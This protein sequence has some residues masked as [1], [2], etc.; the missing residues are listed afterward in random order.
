MAVGVFIV[1][2]GAVAVRTMDS[3]ESTPARIPEVGARFQY[4]LGDLPVDLSAEADVFDID[5]FDIDLFDVPSSTV[6]ELH[7]RG[8]T[9]VCYLSDGSFEGVRPDA[10]RFPDEVVGAP[11]QGFPDERWLDLRATD[12]LLPIMEDRLDQ[13]AAKG[14]DGVEFDNV[15]A[16]ANDSGFELTTDDQLAYLMA[17]SAAARDRDLSP[18]SEI[19]L[20]LGPEVVDD[21]DRAL[22][23][24]CFQ[25]DECDQAAPFVDRD[26]AVFV[27][28]YEVD[29]ADVCDR[30]TDGLSVVFKDLDL[31][32]ELMMCP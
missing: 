26:K 28:E 11:L 1:L 24:Q 17:L 32:S 19:A 31:G 29:P 3:D 30:V 18:G 21:F 27:V 16:F 25:Y 23:E 12:E 10:E 14:F 7:D 5:L 8:R 15:D 20:A 22:I 13:C 4:Q 9:V 6:D 2:G